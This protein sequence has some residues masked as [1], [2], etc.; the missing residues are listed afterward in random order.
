MSE[1]T[2]TADTPHE[3]DEWWCDWWECPA[4]H[5]ASIATGFNY[6]PECG[7]KLVW[8]EGTLDA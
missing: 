3:M 2:M 6:C 8:A 5:K 4:C 7:V 1:V